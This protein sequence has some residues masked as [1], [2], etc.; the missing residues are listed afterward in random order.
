[1]LA[2]IYY[3]TLQQVLNYY[4]HFFQKYCGLQSANKQVTVNL[5][6]LIGIARITVNRGHG[7]Q[8]FAVFPPYLEVW[9]VCG[10]LKSK[11]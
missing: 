11:S 7:N 2:H 8:G 9:L 6:Y 10:T 5:D 1:M 3:T 4:D